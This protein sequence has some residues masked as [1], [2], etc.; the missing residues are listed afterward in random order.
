[1][2]GFDTCVM[3]C[4][5]VAQALAPYADYLVASEDLEPGTGQISPRCCST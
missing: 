3:G 4:V 1:M 2:V 5:E